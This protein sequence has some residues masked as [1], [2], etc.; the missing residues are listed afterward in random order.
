MM[1]R[2][3][4][5]VCTLG[6][7]GSVPSFVRA[8]DLGIVAGTVAPPLG[9][10]REV[11]HA[12]LVARARER[13]ELTDALKPTM[14]AL[15][16]LRE[17]LDTYA[18]EYE[19]TA[20]FQE[21]SVDVTAAA[22]GTDEVLGGAGT[23]SDDGGD[24]GAAEK[25][26][27]EARRMERWEAAT[28]ALDMLRANRQETALQWQAAREAAEEPRG[29]G[30]DASAIGFRP[31]VIERLEAAALAILAT[32]PSSEDDAVRG[33]ALRQLAKRLEVSKERA[34][35]YYDRPSAVYRNSL[36][37]TAQPEAP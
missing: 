36:P 23:L 1:Y 18:D 12:I 28:V 4:V 2:L 3:L 26:A 29:D 24:Q 34:P 7:L 13:R 31:E 19:T 30:K 6:V 10:V 21:G 20:T 11:G 17:V 22:A 9:R 32:P 15:A 16:A 35:A 14:E 8:E 33:E 5:V 37:V 25:E 27:L